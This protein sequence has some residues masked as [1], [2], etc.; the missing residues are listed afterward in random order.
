[1]L[2]A[3]NLC[4]AWAEVFGRCRGG[5]KSEWTIK[6]ENHV[7]QNI[8]YLKCN[9]HG[10]CI[11]SIEGVKFYVTSEATCL[12]NNY[13][14]IYIERERESLMIIHWQCKIILYYHPI[15]NHYWYDFEDN[16]IKV[17][18]VCD[19]ITVYIVA[20]CSATSFPRGF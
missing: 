19:W 3:I 1:M 10:I 8:Y 18:M 20:D 7:K 2:W 14:Y 6:Q 5:S 12:I 16:Y 11:W 9:K 15:T 4:A 17:I 13:I